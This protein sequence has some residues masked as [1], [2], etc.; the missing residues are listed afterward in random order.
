MYLEKQEA[1]NEEEIIQI[2]SDKLILERG[3]DESKLFLKRPRPNEIGEEVKVEEPILVSDLKMKISWTSEQKARA[4]ELLSKMKVIQVYH[5]FNQR[6]PYETLRIWRNKRH[7]SRKKGSN[8]KSKSPELDEE[9]FE[10]FLD[11]R[12]L[13]MPLHNGAITAK[14][15]KIRDELKEE[16]FKEGDEKQVKDLASLKFGKNWLKK[17]KKRELEI[18]N[19]ICKKPYTYFKEKLTNFYTSDE[20]KSNNRFF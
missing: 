10:W 13:K 16:A 6:I 17:I 8:R 18:V 11:A 4:V 9:L 12:A 5:R 7:L 2:Q 20:I 14:A 19:T 3:E 1:N 15:C